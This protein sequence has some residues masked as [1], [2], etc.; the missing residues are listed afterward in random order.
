M[1]ILTTALVALGLSTITLIVGKASEYAK[2]LD[3]LNYELKLKTFKLSVS[4]LK[5]VLDFWLD[6]PTDSTIKVSYPLVLLLYDGEFLAQNTVNN[7]IYKLK[8][9]SQLT[10][11][12]IT[13][14][15]GLLTVGRLLITNIVDI[16]NAIINDSFKVYVEQLKKKIIYNVSL[17]VNNI[18][19]NYKAIA[20]GR[21]E[22]S[23]IERPIRSAPEFDKYFPLPQGK[24]ETVLKNAN[25][26]QT[27]RMMYKV[28]KKDS[29]LLTKVTKALFSEEKTILQTCEKIFNF[30]FDHIKYGLEKGE[31]LKNPLVVYHYGQRLARAFYKKN[32][33]YSKQHTA[34]CDDLAMF[35]A[36]ILRNLNIRYSFRI[37]SY[38]TY[39]NYSHVYVIAFD[40]KGNSI[41]IDPVYHRFN[42][43]KRTVKQ[44]TFEKK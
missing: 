12:N 2:V 39:S 21:M 15:F 4:G 30:C 1:T 32:G 16:T 35:I 13:F 41:I 25:V 40:Q 22:M 9:K 10:V 11:P 19:V 34:D 38:E 29:H 5:I 3:Q 17:S 44:L 33:Y 23:A 24:I 28:V 27:V 7:K 36:C 6:N 20:L 42:A 26:H 14:N 37:A 43:E 31:Q 8:P 18:P